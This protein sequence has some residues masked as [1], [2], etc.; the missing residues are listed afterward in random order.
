MNDLRIDF[1]FSNNKKIV[2]NLDIKLSELKNLLKVTKE[3]EEFQEIEEMYVEYPGD[4]HL[5]ILLDDA[6]IGYLNAS[7]SSEDE[8]SINVVMIK[9]NQRKQGW[10][11]KMIKLF[12]LLVEQKYGT[13]NY[14][15]INAGKIGGCRCYVSAFKQM[16]YNTRRGMN[17]FN[18]NSCDDETITFTFKKSKS[19]TRRSNKN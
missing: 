16:G 14:S 12:V 9:S 2:S 17:S 8:I 19:K 6:I 18:V 3:I 11:Q 10:C 15:L 1:I 5:Y 13:I 4:M 7:F